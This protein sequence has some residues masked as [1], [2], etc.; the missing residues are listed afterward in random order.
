MSGLGV[1][2]FGD[3]CLLNYWAASLFTAITPPQSKQCYNQ[4]ISRIIATQD[5]MLALPLGM[6]CAQ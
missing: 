3:S 6:L 4:T 5:R 2:Y 1:T